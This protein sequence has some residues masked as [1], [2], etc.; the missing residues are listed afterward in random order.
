[1]PMFERALPLRDPHAAP[2]R[3]FD[4]SPPSAERIALRALPRLVWQRLRPL[5]RALANFAAAGGPLS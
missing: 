1:M 2:E 4:D 5:L 3:E